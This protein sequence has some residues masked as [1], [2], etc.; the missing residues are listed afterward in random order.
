MPRVLDIYASN[1][2]FYGLNIGSLPR[3][4]DLY[5]WNIGSLCLEYRLSMPR[6]S[7]IRASCIGF[8]CFEYTYINTFLKNKSKFAKTMKSTIHKCVLNA[9]AAPNPTPMNES[10]NYGYNN[11]LFSV[12]LAVHASPTWGACGWPQA[13]GLGWVRLGAGSCGS[14]SLCIYICIYCLFILLMI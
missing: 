13:Q 1:M 11:F 9:I 3:I 5:A 14:L 10:A 4:S 8:L 7:D 12:Y 6:I 2:D